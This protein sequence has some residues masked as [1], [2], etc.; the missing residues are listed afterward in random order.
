M[1]LSLSATHYPPTEALISPAGM[2]RT[3]GFEEVEAIALTL[4]GVEVTTAW[5]PPALEVR[6]KMFACVA[7]HES[8]EP[9]TL[10]V[11]MHFPQTCAH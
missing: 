5:G 10:V 11:K 2:P 3:T 6:G 9:N 8:A 1:Q 7:S 4:P